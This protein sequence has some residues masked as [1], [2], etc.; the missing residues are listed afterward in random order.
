MEKYRIEHTQ[1]TIYIDNRGQAINGYLVY[2]YLPEYDESHELRVPKLD[3]AV[4][5]AAAEQLLANRKA[6]AD[7]T[8]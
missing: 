3:P 4:V 2:V 5:K 6:I 7:L 8:G 1:P